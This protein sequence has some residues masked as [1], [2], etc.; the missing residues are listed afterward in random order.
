MITDLPIKRIPD[1]LLKINHV[2][3]HSPIPLINILKDSLYYPSSGFDGDP[4]KY[5]SGNFYSFIYV[6]YGN[7][8]E[9]L[10]DLLKSPGFKGYHIILSR[11][12]QDNE[13][14]PNGWPKSATTIIDTLSSDSNG[15]M[16]KPFAKWIVWQRNDG[17]DNS[18]GSE[19]FSLLYVCADAI[20][21]FHALYL[22]NNRYPL[23]IPIIQPGHNFGGNWTNFEDPD[24]VFA[25][26]VFNNTA[27]KPK[28]LLYGGMGKRI[29]YTQPCWPQYSNHIGFLE[30]S[31]NGSIGLWIHQ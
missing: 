18:H 9:E 23:G 13:L 1:W 5:L 3:E 16:Q 12:I 29:L 24:E 30:K 11:N 10:D 21:A 31:N 17:L 22:S 20:A 25:T 2:D 28:I 7:T 14:V 19:R 8:N 15:F 27:G 6:D 26:T 4:V